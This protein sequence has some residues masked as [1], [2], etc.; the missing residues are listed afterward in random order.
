MRFSGL[1]VAV[2]LLFS[3]VVVAQHSSGGGGSSGGSHSSYSGGG[4]SS[5]GPATHSAGSGLSASHSS[6]QPSGSNAAH[7]I[8]EPDVARVPSQPEKRT[9]FSLLRH[10]FRKP[11]PKTEADLQRR[12]CAKKGSCPVC[13]VGQTA[14]KNGACVA[15]QA[16]LCRTGEYWNDGGCVVL[17]NF[18][19][20]CSLDPDGE[21]MAARKNMEA[22][23]RSME[24]VCLQD[25]AGHECSEENVLYQRAV[26]LHRQR[27]ESHM[28]AYEEC[29]RS[30]SFFSPFGLYYG[31][32]FSPLGL[33]SDPLLP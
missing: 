2:I 21:L 7:A 1:A 32:L 6:H 23:T 10:P 28:R 30:W 9:F 16:L 12:I 33:Y 19:A 3:S 29:Q 26:D 18:L 15:P 24:A 22:A 11:Q 13:P 14:G 4:S 17:A 8:R 5:G 25:P 20:N 27:Q 31:P